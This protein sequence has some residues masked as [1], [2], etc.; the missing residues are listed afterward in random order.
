MELFRKA[1]SFLGIRIPDDR[2]LVRAM[3]ICHLLLEQ[4]VRFRGC[5]A[6]SLTGAGHRSETAWMCGFRRRL[7]WA[8]L[9]HQLRAAR[10][11]IQAVRWTCA[12]LQTAK[13][14]RCERSRDCSR[15]SCSGTHSVCSDALQDVRE[16]FLLARV[17]LLYPKCGMQMRCIIHLRL[18]ILDAIILSVCIGMSLCGGVETLSAERYCLGLI[19]NQTHW[20]L[21]PVAS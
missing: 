16:N 17:A 15:L 13:A 4:S 3:D 19:C 6:V 18:V 5:C 7:A 10:C 2:T 1:G 12:S 8:L 20:H 9:K 14:Q 21:R 11:A